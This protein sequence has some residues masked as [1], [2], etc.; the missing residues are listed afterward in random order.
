MRVISIAV[1]FVITLAAVG[2]VLR[3]PFGYAQQDREHI[4]ADGSR[5]HWTGTDDLGRDRTVRVAGALLLSLLGAAAAAALAAGVSVGAGMSAAMAPAWMG[6]VILYVSDLALTLPWLF[7]LMM[8]RAALPL[9]LGPGKS[10]TVTFLLL[11]LLGWPVFVRAN[12]ARVKAL[13]GADWLV[14]GRASGLRPMQL[15]KQLLPHLAP[16]VITQFLIYVPVC[17]VAE[18]N[19]G[20]M[21][22]GIA[23]PLPSWGSMLL[24]LQ[25]SAVLAT[26]HWI[27]LPIVLLVVVLLGF[28]T[29][30]N[31]VKA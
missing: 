31:E 22:L 25:S 28:E 24:S 27:Y 11:G 17:I 26:S 7:L 12:Y 8:V 5:E 4:S 30:V 18:A 15:G 3:S 6:R 29:L 9:N 21:G 14:H 20:A 1:L 23:E 10:A 19:L 13:R 16:I 2:V